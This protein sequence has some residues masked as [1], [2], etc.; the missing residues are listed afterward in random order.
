MV[1]PLHG[2]R[3]LDA[4]RVLTGPFCSM[5]LGDLGAEIIKIE[6]PGSGDDTR[7]WGPPFIGNESA[8]FLSV[9]R[10]KKSVTLNLETQKGKE[11]FYALAEKS[12][13]LLENFRPGVAEK[14]G[15]DYSSIA[16]KNARLIYCSIT[17]FGQTGRYRERAGYDIVLQGMGGLMGVTGEPDRPPVRVGVAMSDIGAGMYAATAILSA[18]L[19]RERSGRGQSVDVALFD[20]TVS[21]MTYMA[22]YYF[23][24]GKDP[25]RSGSAHPTIVPYQC[26]RTLDE[27]YLTIAAGNDKLFRNLCKALGR[28]ELAADARFTNNSQ[29]IIHRL[30]LVSI[31]EGIFLTKTR[32]EWIRILIEADVPTGP[33]Y[34]MSELFNDPQVKDREMLVELEHPRLG[35]L[36]Q[37]GIPMKFSE[38]EPE[39]K[40]SPPMLG[41]HTA[42][43]LQTLLGYDDGLLR[44]LK[45]KGVI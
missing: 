34:S 5:M 14:L 39:I 38:T 2:I 40:S 37:I 35:K 27:N 32:D 33:V 12:D 20:S 24:T 42:E 3:V 29:R 18:L 11:I 25:S 15:I 41:E 30:E 31:I 28:E 21:W 26:F 9:N 17:G 23:A 1:G 13:V 44:E 43:V 4:S 8:Y 45:E 19:A 6:R 36:K 16:K 10:N 7:Q 22:G